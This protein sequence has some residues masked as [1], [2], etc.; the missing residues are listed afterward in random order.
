MFE[1]G[2]ECEKARVAHPLLVLTPI[3]HTLSSVITHLHHQAGLCRNGQEAV[4]I[5]QCLKAISSVALQNTCTV[6][7][8]FGILRQ[9]KQK[10]TSFVSMNGPGRSIQA[11]VKEAN[12]NKT[13]VRPVS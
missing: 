7:D 4:T 10:L 5:F 13:T 1:L 9:A 6:S 8:I 12:R 2:F 11:S 3:I